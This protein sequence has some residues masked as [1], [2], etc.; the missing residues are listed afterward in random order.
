MGEIMLETENLRFAY[1]PG[2]PVLN[3]IDLRIGKGEKIVLLG[4]NGSGKST[5]M[6]NLNGSLS[7]R[8]GTIKIGGAVVPD[9]RKGRETLRRNAAILFQDPDDQLF[10]TSVYEDISFGPSCDG[11]EE[12]EIHRRVGEALEI[13]ELEG[14]RDRP[15]HEL[16]Y[17]QK[18][19]V[20]LAGLFVMQT[21]LVLLDEPG[22]GLDP[23]SYENL[24]K[25]LEV[26]QN[27]GSTL[28]IATHDLEFAF[29]WSES[30]VLMQNGEIFCREA[31]EQL[32]RSPRL[33]EAARLSLPLPMRLD[34]ALKR[35][36]GRELGGPIPGSLEALLRMLE[37]M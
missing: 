14:L 1:E 9:S 6:M 16:S 24:M 31:K 22:A 26:W 13:F 19:R 37:E 4:A 3:G 21:P 23:A 15:V 35:L 8:N 36:G 12:D 34:L 33:L 32:L 7:P 25:T 5:L 28:V 10:S 18:K 20:A 27:R 17:G 11:L 30:V 29:E 2:R